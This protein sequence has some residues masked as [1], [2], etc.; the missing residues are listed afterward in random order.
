MGDFHQNATISTLH[1]LTNLPVERLE[2]QLKEFSGSRPIALLLPSLYSELQG[3]ALE[4]IVEQLRSVNYISDIIIG[5]DR[6]GPEEYAHAKE[7]FSKLPQNHHILWNDGPRLKALD[8]ELHSHGL[9]PREPGKG[10]NVWYCLGYIL[11]LRR[12][13]VVALHDCDILTYDRRMLARLIYPV[14]NPHFSYV[15]SKG[16]YARVANGSMNGRVTRLL[17]TPLLW[18]L[19]RVIGPHDFIDYLDGF[20]Y[21]LAGE[22]AMRASV[23]P[24]LRIPSD[25][26]LEI[27]MLSEVRRNL[28]PRLIC[29]VDIADTYDHK[30]Q[31]LSKDDPN[32]G[33]SRMSTDITKAIYRKLATD[34]IAFSS[35]TFRTL[36]ATYYRSALDLIETYYHDAA[37]NGLAFDRHAEEQA[38]ELFAK[39]IVE[40]GHVF[41]DNP[42]EVPFI[43]SWNRI[44]NAVP[45]FVERLNKSVKADMADAR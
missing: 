41:L 31:P 38:V 44:H 15:F 13:D 33:L 6:A 30:H 19:K 39:N 3:P 18:S 17:I 40:A 12:I 16:Y 20:R 23:L 37:I 25:W 32:A 36:K 24:D 45:D 28:N 2:I 27:G 14:A 8:A 5:L 9:A 10:R 11:S 4:G 26:G 21:P 1:E 34:G 35:E 29:Q 43:P 7:Y 42:M 22:F